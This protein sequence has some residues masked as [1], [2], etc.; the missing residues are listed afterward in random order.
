MSLE[1]HFKKIRSEQY[2]ESEIEFQDVEKDQ[3]ISMI[4]Y[5]LEESSLRSKLND[6][7]KGFLE[8]MKKRLSDKGFL[9]DRQQEILF[10]ILN[11]YGPE[12]EREQHLLDETFASVY[13][14]DFIYMMNYY[15]RY[16]EKNHTEYWGHY[17]IA[18]RYKD[19]FTEDPNSEV[20]PTFLEKK[21]LMDNKYAR[22]ILTTLHSEPKFKLG[23]KIQITRGKITPDSGWSYHIKGKPGVVISHHPEKIISSCKGSLIYKI[24]LFGEEKSRFVEE[25]VLIKQ[26]KKKIGK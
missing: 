25:R 15:I 8:D 3:K 10:K 26:R 2:S 13:R 11:S 23:S 9:S 4:T 1:E 16:C 6:W 12:G 14:D 5:V 18:Q 19:I 21:V 22:K 24:L 17:R 20:I 7:Q